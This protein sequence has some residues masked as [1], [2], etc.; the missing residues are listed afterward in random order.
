M[1][2]LLSAASMND[3][4][5]S[6]W[7]CARARRNSGA[8]VQLRRRGDGLDPFITDGGHY[9]LD[10]ACEALPD[11]VAVDYRLKSIPGVVEHGLF[12]GLARVVIVGEDNEARVLEL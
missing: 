10:C 5:L 4:I 3:T 1:S 8:S 12:V 6:P 11:P 7:C 2:L 9:L